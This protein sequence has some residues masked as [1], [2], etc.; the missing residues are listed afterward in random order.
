MTKLAC[1]KA[2]MR[3]A[4]SADE[5]LLIL[6]RDMHYQSCSYSFLYEWRKTQ[7]LTSQL[8]QFVTWSIYWPMSV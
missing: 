2:S 7:R 4:N 1:R 5:E 3:Y 6:F 8:N